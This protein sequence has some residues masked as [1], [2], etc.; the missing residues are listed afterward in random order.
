MSETFNSQYLRDPAA[1]IQQRKYALA[2]ALQKEGMNA[3]PVVGTGNNGMQ[4]IARVLQGALGGYMANRAE[5]E[6]REMSGAV[7]FLL[8]DA[9][10]YVTG[11]NLPIDG[12]YTAK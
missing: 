2:Q 4:A 7:V 11:V 1:A 6:A 9:S 8:S 12:G 10:S 5:G 3:A